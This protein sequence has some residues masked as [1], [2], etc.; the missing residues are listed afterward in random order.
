MLRN[1]I[2]NISIYGILPIVG[3]FLNFLLV[4]IYAK[5]FSP[6]Q[7]GII[8][9]YDAFVF[10]LLV[11][12]SFEIPVAMG[13]Y[14]YDEDNF[15]HRQKIVNTS[16]ILTV[17]IVALTIVAALVF[18]RE[19]LEHFLVGE[20]SKGL[21]NIA[22]VW[23]G[24]LA[25][26]TFL[27]FIPRYDNRPKVYVTVGVISIVT[28]LLFSILFVVVLKVGLRGVLYGYICGNVASIFMYIWVSRHYFK[29][30]FSRRYAGRML[31]YAFPLLLGSVILEVWKPWLR[32][33]ITLYY[34]IAIVGMYAFAMRLTSV[35]MIVH[36][37]FK[38]AW[39]PLLFEKKA[40]FIQG[41]AM[42]KV[43]GLVAL[44]SIILGC[45]ITCFAKEA[46]IIV[47]SR[48][49][50][51]S[52]QITGLLA[53]SGV[54]QMLCELRGFGP[55]ISDRTYIVTIANVIA[56]AASTAFLMT[57]K[58]SAGLFGI[59][60]A[61]ILYELIC[62]VILVVYTRIKYKI[63]LHNKWELPLAAM[64][65]LCVYLSV[66]LS[67]FRYRVVAA[68]LACLLGAYIFF[69]RYYKLKVKLRDSGEES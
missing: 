31:V 60:Y 8:D 52:V 18:K 25:I 35:N 23:L 9:L 61:C 57:V 13:R 12:A 29:A 44:A 30:V 53:V 7:Y 34:P 37:A 16:L 4:P 19:A 62:Y 6:E 47:G 45:L 33:L 22:I 56:I 5:C 69:T 67:H 28:K 68:G 59:G 58:D 40:D 20:E 26:N 17:V 21:F 11:V 3:K 10:F 15:A 36:G 32:H 64:L 63:A 27:S 50:L 46:T 2:K 14:F 66:T 24:S 38:I 41:D 65:A 55:Y 51:D 49:Y 54:I 1:F 42:K 39:K 48:D 43:S